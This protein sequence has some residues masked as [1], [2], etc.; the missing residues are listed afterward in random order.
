MNQTF[1]TN[2]IQSKFIKNIIYNTPL[3]IINTVRDGDYIIQDFSYLYGSY[4]IRCDTSGILNSTDSS[5]RAAYTIIDPAF[6]LDYFN[7]KRT[8]RFESTYEYYD[9]DTHKWLGRYLRFYRDIWH[10]DLM[11][12][13]NCF[14]GVYTSKFFIDTSD[15]YGEDVYVVEQSGYD[16]YQ[17]GSS[18]FRSRYQ[19]PENKKTLQIPVKFNRKYTIAIDCGTNI[20]LSL[21]F[22]S[23]GELLKVPIQGE[24]HDLTLEYNQLNLDNSY[25]KICG[26][27]SYPS[28]SFKR[29]FIYETLNQN[30]D[31]EKL[32]QRYE[33]YLYLLIQVPV[34]NNSSVV[35]LEGDYLDQNVN[36]IFNFDGLQDGITDVELDKL[37]VSGISLLQFSDEVRHPFSNRLIEYLLW[38]T[39]DNND[40]IGDNIKRLQDKLS[41]LNS[42]G[43]V[44]GVWA[45]RLR[46]YLFREYIEY[47]KSKNIDVLGYVDKDIEKYV[48]G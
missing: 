25:N 5:N 13:Y 27:F 45:D 39:I 37:C 7:P 16:Y 12:F 18:E 9:S 8:E 14:S 44:P 31:F 15:L 42:D 22:I 34:S 30:S 17:Q 11:P 24:V 47:K 2:T 36:K 1:Y 32:F 29:P 26:A 33:N 28:T 3:P 40:L 20:E 21:A 48:F 19:A 6:F 35:V 4:V 10:Q 41:I 43:V 38:N 23:N 46:A